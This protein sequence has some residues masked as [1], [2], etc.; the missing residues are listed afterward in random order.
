M[1]RYHQ[2]VDAALR[3]AVLHSATSF[4]WFGSR[5]PSLA[6]SVKRALTPRT[7]RNYLLVQLQMQLYGDFYRQGYA[8][9][10]AKNI[11]N[12]P[13]MGRT[14]FVDALSAANCGR[15]SW[16]HGWVVSAIAD[17]QVAVRRDGLTLWTRRQDCLARPGG[18]VE[19]DGPC[20]L[21]LPKECLNISPGFYMVHSDQPFTHDRAETM[22]RFYWNLEADGAARFVDAA[23]R[24]LNRDGLPFR[25]KVLKDPSHYT[26]CDAGVL[27]I[28][29]R[30]SE[31]VAAVI[32]EIYPV[33]RGSLRSGTPVFTKCLA[34]GLGLAEDPGQGDSFGQH[35]CRLLADGMILAFEQG[36]KSSDAR[37][38]TVAD[39]FA[40]DGIRLEQ[41]FLNAGSTDDYCWDFTH[42]GAVA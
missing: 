15:G 25:L 1:E 9:P 6:R 32:R 39:R 24:M 21:R 29:K 40:R 30:E 8:A 35:R 41:P 33:M 11:L 12:A 27:Y 3:A 14:P 16:E 4:S 10:A 5:N 28:R 13:A 22:V 19:V 34:P 26:R 37:M 2:L 36:R 31:A 7:A 18:E 20:A 17:D 23:T 42:A 38:R